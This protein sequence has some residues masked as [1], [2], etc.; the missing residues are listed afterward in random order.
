MVD[1]LIIVLLGGVATAGYRRGV[2]LTFVALIV[3]AMGALLGA[4]VGLPFG[5]PALVALVFGCLAGLA[6]GL[7]INTIWE[8]R[9][10]REENVGVLRQVDRAAGAV[11]SM[12]LILVL[13]WFAGV[14]ATLSP[15]SQAGG[16][17]SVRQSRVV[18]GL[19]GVVSPTGPVAA[20]AARTGLV[21]GLDGPIII[22]DPP[23]D[24]ILQRAE[25]NAVASRIVRIAGIACGR[26]DTGTGWPIA[27]NTVVTNAHVV[28]GHSETTVEVQGRSGQLPASIVAFD[29]INDIAVLYV[30]NLQLPSIPI[31]VTPPRHGAPILVIGYPRNE[32][33]VRGA[34]RFDRIVEYP[35]LD[36]YAAKRTKIQVLVFRGDV[37]SG[38]SGSP[39]LNETGEVVGMVSAQALG[40]AVEGGYGMPVSLISALASRANGAQVSPGPCTGPPRPTAL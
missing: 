4:A 10:E 26:R 20:V 14:V 7:L 19:L 16:V 21:P 34:A 15:N 39:I 36:I 38:N 22:V 6:F 24:T 37:R 40:Q 13:V 25:P 27:T 2:V 17:K 33:L 32:G 3:V 23:D 18:G 1:L 9:F 8:E 12:G 29:P 5:A 35:S 31:T 28:A 11:L 30:P